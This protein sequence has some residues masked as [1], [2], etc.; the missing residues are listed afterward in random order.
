MSLMVALVSKIIKLRFHDNPS[1]SRH[2]TKNENVDLVMAPQTSV[3]NV[4]VVHCPIPKNF[5]IITS[6]ANA[7]IKSLYLKP[8][9]LMNKVL[10]NSATT[11]CTLITTN[12]GLH[13]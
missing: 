8:V 7:V 4:M 2:F 1:N 6:Q 9:L 5:M 11:V 13:P 10:P 3:Q 12:Q